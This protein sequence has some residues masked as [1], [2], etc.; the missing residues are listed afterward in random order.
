MVKE[1]ELQGGPDD[2]AGAVA[3]IPRDIG[4]SWGDKKR[5]SGKWN[6]RSAEGEILPGPLGEQRDWAQHLDT[7]ASEHAD[8]VPVLVE[9]FFG[10]ESSTADACCEGEAAE[11]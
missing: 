1:I 4:P 9:R 3:G 2:E 10:L 11:W 5:D 6:Y 8:A 7:E